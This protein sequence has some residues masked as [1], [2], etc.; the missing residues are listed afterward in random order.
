MLLLCAAPGCVRDAVL[1]N[2]VRKA[3][4]QAAALASVADLELAEAALAAELLE[5]EALYLRSPHDARVLGLL[6]LGYARLADGFIEARRLEALAADSGAE[7][8]RQAE[9]RAD[10]RARRDFYQDRARAGGSREL[11][12]S[13]VLGEHLSS[14]EQACRAKNRARYEAELTRLLA[15]RPERPEA[16]L[17]LALA[18]RHA[19]SWLHAEISARCGF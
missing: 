10:A 7:A 6:A 8:T 17:T 4:L 15:E 18:Q 13:G 14:A 2:D 9:R 16:R 19:R 11:P 3:Q 1:E 5:L 12:P